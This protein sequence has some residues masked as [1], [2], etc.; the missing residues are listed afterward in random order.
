MSYKKI[1]Q[2]LVKKVLELS[3]VY[4]QNR[5]VSFVIFGSVAR[6]SFRPDSD[7]DIL[8]VAEKLPKGRVKRVEE[9]EK[10]IERKLEFELKALYKKGIYPYF[11]PI[12]KT[13]EEVLRGSW[14]FLDMVFDAKILYDKDDFFKN[15]L[16][17][18]KEKLKKIGAKRIFKG[19]AWYWVLKP[20]YKVG[21]IIDI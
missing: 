4:Y 13:K 17:S 18:L 12:F 6:D 20:D 1:Y 21:D 5:L 11:S 15:F 14:L 9:F 3:K 16:F 10:N 19:N 2:D 7:I 8:I